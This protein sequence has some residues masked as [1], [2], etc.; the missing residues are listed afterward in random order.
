LQCKLL[1]NGSPA[2]AATLAAG[3]G[4]NGKFPLQWGIL[5]RRIRRV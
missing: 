5:R 1:S 3:F 4:F 2:P